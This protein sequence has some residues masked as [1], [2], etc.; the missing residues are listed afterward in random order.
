MTAMRRWGVALVLGGIALSALFVVGIVTTRPEDGV[1][2]G[3][4]FLFML[5]VPATVTGV[6]LLV[7]AGRRRAAMAL[8]GPTSSGPVA[9]PGS[10]RA[11]WSLALGILG[12]LVAFFPFAATITISA[13]VIVTDTAASV[14][15]I[16]LG[17]AVRR[18]PTG[19]TGVALAG[20]ITGIIGLV[21]AV[22]QVISLILE[23]TIG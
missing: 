6:V 3:A 9:R 19:A 1:N 11:G 17:R 13:A 20:L 23:S 21:F 4:G 2:I 18:E 12:I 14:A 22:L 16:V 10:T 5:A 15:A 7:V 8:G